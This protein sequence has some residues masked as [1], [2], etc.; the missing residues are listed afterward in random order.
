MCQ[1]ILEGAAQIITE[2]LFLKFLKGQ[3]CTRGVADPL[4]YHYDGG[5]VLQCR[6]YEGAMYKIKAT[7]K[8]FRKSVLVLAYLTQA[9]VHRNHISIIILDI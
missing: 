9:S 8:P 5:S 6:Q 4:L 1:V 3:T 2:I 7:D